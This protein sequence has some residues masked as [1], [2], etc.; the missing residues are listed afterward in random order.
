MLWGS[1]TPGLRAES[2]SALLWLSLQ[3]RV[4]GGEEEQLR[5]RGTGFLG[6]VA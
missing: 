3:G 2:R 1:A 5:A 6:Q 4:F